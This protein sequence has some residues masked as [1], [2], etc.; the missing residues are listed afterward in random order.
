MRQN[1][2]HQTH[3]LD[4]LTKRNVAPGDTLYKF[5]PLKYLKLILNNGILRVDR[6]ESWEDVYENY[7]YKQTFCHGQYPVGVN[8]VVDRIYGQCWSYTPDTDAM[9]R[10]YSIYKMNEPLNVDDCAVRLR[11][12]A[13]RLFDVFYT[14]D[15]CMADTFIG[16]VE[17]LPQQTIENQMRTLSQKT[18]SI[19]NLRDTA[20]DFLLK[21]RDA[22]IHENEARVIITKSTADNAPNK[23]LEFTIDPDALFKEYCIDPRVTAQAEYRIR[24]ALVAAGANPAKIT[25]SRLYTIQN[26]FI[27]NV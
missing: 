15:N 4:Q 25:K 10:I 5:M 3:Y 19:G 16:R 23:F 8:D 14:D 24:Q 20:I 13:E 2:K 6:V 26:K 17:Y 18:L 1:I 22:F 9:W 11:V 21:K 27:L 7:F 12:N